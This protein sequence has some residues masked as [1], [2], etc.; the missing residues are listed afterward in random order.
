[1]Q[2]E[3][4]CLSMCDLT[5]DDFGAVY[6]SDEEVMCIWAFRPSTSDSSIC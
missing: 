2:P 4:R 6:G 1:M 5:D 3:T